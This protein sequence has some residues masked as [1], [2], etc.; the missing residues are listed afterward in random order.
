L[1][2]LLVDIILLSIVEYPILSVQNTIKNKLGK[3]MHRLGEE[4][5]NYVQN[6]IRE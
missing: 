3:S 4:D 1:Q 6:D 2:A 5:L